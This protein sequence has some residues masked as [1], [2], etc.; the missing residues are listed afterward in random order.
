MRPCQAEEANT[1]EINKICIVI[2]IFI[3]CYNCAVRARRRKKE[4][5]M[6]LYTPL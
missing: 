3:C 5:K 4:E 2:G 6:S 1:D